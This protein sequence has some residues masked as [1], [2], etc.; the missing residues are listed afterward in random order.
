MPSHAINSWDWISNCYVYLTPPDQLYQ[1]DLM[2]LS[3]LK[4]RFSSAFHAIRRVVLCV[5]SKVLIL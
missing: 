4:G 2:K 3:P 1:N 5:L